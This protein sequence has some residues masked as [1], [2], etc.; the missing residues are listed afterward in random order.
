MNLRMLFF[1]LSSIE[2]LLVQTNR[3]MASFYEDCTPQRRR[4]LTHLCT[5]CADEMETHFWHMR[6]LH[7]NWIDDLS[8]QVDD[9]WDRIVDCINVKFIV[10][11]LQEMV[12]RDKKITIPI[13]PRFTDEKW[14]KGVLKGECSDRP[15]T[16]LSDFRRIVRKTLINLLESY[17]VSDWSD[18]EVFTD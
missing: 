13:P 2:F 11:E 16:L 12:I 18:T 9:L 10:N 6:D 17:D 8:K 7:S 4:I 14:L 3:I 1:P 15:P 5:A